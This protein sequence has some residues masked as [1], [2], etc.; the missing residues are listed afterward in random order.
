MERFD[1]TSGHAVGFASEAERRAAWE[2][3]RDTLLRDTPRS[4]KRGGGT[5]AMPPPSCAS[6]SSATSASP[7]SA[8]RR[9]PTPATRAACTSPRDA[10]PLAA[11]LSPMT[12]LCRPKLP[13]YRAHIQSADDRRRLLADCAGTGFEDVRDT[14]IIRVFVSTGARLAEVAGMTLEDIDLDAA[15]VVVMGKGRRE[16]N[17]FL[18]AKAIKV[19]DR[20]GRRTRRQH[21][22]L[23]LPGCGWASAA[24]SPRRASARWAASGAGA[25]PSTPS[26]P[27]QRDRVIGA[28]V[29]PAGGIGLASPKSVDVCVAGH[30]D[31]ETGNLRKAEQYALEIVPEPDFW[32]VLGLALARR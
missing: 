14:A 2:A 17:S 25:T 13:E 26:R 9:R 29:E 22:S 5:T 31:A 8:S 1:L 7:R 11:I 21:P 15:T 20:H 23:S 18:D 6:T 28:R 12:V 19:L 30:R 10:R 32:P 27:A 4:R 3:S 24:S 16:R